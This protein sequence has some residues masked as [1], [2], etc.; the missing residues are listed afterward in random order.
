MKTRL[1]CPGSQSGP[2]NPIA[3]NPSKPG[4]ERWPGIGVP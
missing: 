3:D 2:A 4:A 1:N